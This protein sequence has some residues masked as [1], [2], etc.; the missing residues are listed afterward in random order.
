MN[1]TAINST[2]QFCK[3]DRCLLARLGVLEN[4]VVGPADVG[5]GV[6]RGTVKL[7]DTTAVP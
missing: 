5:A 4:I 6:V 1:M 3:L 7:S 2:R